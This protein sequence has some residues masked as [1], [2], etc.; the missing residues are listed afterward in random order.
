MSDLE[1]RIQERMRELIA[2]RR[3]DREFM[4]RLRERVEQD[5][6][7][8]DRLKAMDREEENALVDSMMAEVR[9]LATHECR[10]PKP[11]TM[12]FP[13]DQCLDCLKWRNAGGQPDE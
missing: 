13:V 5:K 9:R 8:L 11:N 7:I 2:P 10:Y 1:R 12:G 3:N 4:R 6:P